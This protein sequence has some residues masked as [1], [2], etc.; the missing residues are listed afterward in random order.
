MNDTFKNTISYDK[1]V[2]VL[3]VGGGLIGLSTSLFLS[4]H[5]IH[6]LLIERHPGTAI[7]PRVVGFTPRTME[8]FR[9]VGVE[10]AIHQAEPPTTLSG[11]RWRTTLPSR[12]RCF[13]GSARPR[14]Q[15]G[16]RWISSCSMRATATAREPS[17]G[18]QAMRIFP[19]RSLQLNG[20]ESRELTLRISY[21]N[22]RASRS[23]RWTSSGESGC[24]CSVLTVMHG[25]RLLNV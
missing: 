23:R 13:P 12:W 24:C 20:R 1:T 17:R 11:A 10:E 25:R 22:E 5:G 8:L 21:S 7:H 3:I 15:P 9:S 19:W 16:S 4:W 6:S 18:K 2:P 14:D